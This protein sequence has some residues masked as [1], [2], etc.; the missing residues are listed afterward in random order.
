MPDLRQELAVQQKQQVQD[1]KPSLTSAVKEPFS[2]SSLA[3]L[4]TPPLTPPDK[5]TEEKTVSSSP[6]QPAPS[7]STKSRPPASAESL[8]TPPPSTSRGQFVCVCCGRTGHGEAYPSNFTFN[9][10]SHC[11]LILSCN[12]NPDGRNSW[13][14]WLFVAL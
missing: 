8:N 7:T 13:L 12:Q 14:T 9:S 2:S 5:R 6:G 1:R 3:G 11:V 4:P 10:C